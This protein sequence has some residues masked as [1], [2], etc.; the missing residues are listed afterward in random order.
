METE[1][2]EPTAAE[3][4]AKMRIAGWLRVLASLVAIAYAV[5]TWPGG[6]TY[7]ELAATVTVLAVALIVAV[8]ADWVARG[9]RPVR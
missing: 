1:E 7:R 8:C 4:A 5:S 3:L 9:E 2:T 6:I